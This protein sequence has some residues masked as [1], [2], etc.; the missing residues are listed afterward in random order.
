MDP[1]K[2]RRLERNGILALKRENQNRKIEFELHYLSS[3]SL[4]DRFVLMFKKNH[5]LKINLVNNG[6]RESPSVVKRK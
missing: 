5:E 3:L 2:I 4:K 6:H 1:E